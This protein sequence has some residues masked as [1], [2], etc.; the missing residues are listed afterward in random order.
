MGELTGEK[1][2]LEII[3]FWEYDKKQ[4]YDYLEVITFSIHRRTHLSILYEP[5]ISKNKI[6]SNTIIKQNK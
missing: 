2:N 1:C 4:L 5:A 3:T 6:K